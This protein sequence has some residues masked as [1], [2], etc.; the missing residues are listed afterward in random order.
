MKKFGLKTNVSF[1]SVAGQLLVI[2]ISRLSD[3]VLRLRYRPIECTASNRRGV[4]KPSGCGNLPYAMFG[5]K[6]GICSA[7]N[8]CR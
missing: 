5:G 7:V 2:G 3:P 6:H 1:S 8:V 4:F